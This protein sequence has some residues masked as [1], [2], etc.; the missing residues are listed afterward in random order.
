LDYASLTGGKCEDLRRG[1]IGSSNADGQRRKG[2]GEER[3][4]NHQ[5]RVIG[6]TVE[7][8]PRAARL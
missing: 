3:P 4:D 7:R 8:I 2:S 5:A 1:E 6:R